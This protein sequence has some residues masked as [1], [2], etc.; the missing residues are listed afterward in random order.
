M[1]KITAITLSLLAASFLTGCGGSGDDTSTTSTTLVPSGNEVTVVDG[2]IQGAIV[3]DANGVYLGVTDRNGKVNFAITNI[4]YPIYAEGG[5]IDVN[6]DGVYNINDNDIEMPVGMRLSA[7]TG[8]VISPITTLLAEG[9]SAES[10]SKASGIPEEKLLADPIALNDTELEKLNQIAYAVVSS[11]SIYE[12]K[13]SLASATGESTSELPS[14]GVGTVATVP[15][16]SV[17][18]VASIVANAVPSKVA[19]VDFVNKVT[20]ID[21]TVDAS[22]IE[23]IVASDKVL[24]ATSAVATATTAAPV[25]LTTPTT[26]VAPATTDLPSVATTTTLTD[27]DTYVGPSEVPNFTDFSNPNPEPTTLDSDLP[28]FNDNNVTEV[29]TTTTTTT[30]T[31]SALPTFTY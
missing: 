19:V 5:F 12:F 16:G 27:S 21:D 6:G 8:N 15:L 1:I 13:T 11:N 4:L 7:E 9:V 31:T 24:V 3:K 2:Y 14:F 26:V 25:T 18:A 17:D 30:S 22:A 10:L 29:P 28:N 23:Q 20:T